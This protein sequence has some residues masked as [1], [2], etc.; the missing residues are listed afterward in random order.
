MV[1]MPLAV[2]WRGYGARADSAG[3]SE[4]RGEGRGLPR[5]VFVL[6]LPGVSGSRWRL[7]RRWMLREPGRSLL[8]QVM[9]ERA[10]RSKGRPAC[11]LDSGAPIGGSRDRWC[12]ER[13]QP[14]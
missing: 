9:P 8:R 12:G 7:L 10:G 6:L 3:D 4:R 13:C 2:G 11:L 1:G 14:P 5:R